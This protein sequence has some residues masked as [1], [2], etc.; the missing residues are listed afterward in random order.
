VESNI[1]AN[2]PFK[3]SV[4][5]QLF[6]EPESMSSLY[7]LM[8]ANEVVAVADRN[9]NSVD[10][11]Q[12]GKLPFGLRADSLN[13]I[14][15]LDWLRNRTDNLYRPYMN[16]VYMARRVGRDLDCIL[17]DS[18]ALSV[19][20]Q[21]WINRPDFPEMTWDAL[22]KTRD[23]NETLTNVALTGKISYLDW[24]K[25]REGTTSLFTTKGYFPKAIRGNTMLKNNGTQ[26]REW[27][28]TVIGKALGLPVKTL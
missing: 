20:D 17:R 10:V 2:A 11:R 18:Y 19:T 8:H 13:C 5:T 23:Q 26:E 27:A 4:F 25:A 1:P 3:G 14:D 12:P 9:A 15:F 6:S 22:Q 7:T 24:E 21:F 28:A 16:K